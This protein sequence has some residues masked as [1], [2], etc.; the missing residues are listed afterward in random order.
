M[1]SFKKMLFNWKHISGFRNR[2]ITYNAKKFVMTEY[3]VNAPNKLKN[4]SIVFFSDTHFRKSQF[5]YAEL[6]EYIN[7][8]K[9]DWIVFGGDLIN[10]MSY[11]TSA[12]EFLSQL[13][14]KKAKLAVLGNWEMRR[15]KWATHE[16]WDTFFKKSG[17][18]LLAD[19]IYNSSP[20]HFIGINPF[21]E[22]AI[23]PPVPSGY[24]SC[25]ISHYP[26][27]VIDIFNAEDFKKID[28]IL[29]GHTH[30][31]Q[32]RLP[33]L[34]ALKTSNNYWK[35]LEY[36]HYQ[37]KNTQSNM[38]ISNGIGYSGPKYRFLCKP[39]IV[40]INFVK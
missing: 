23:L 38:I 30:G 25:L 39:E 19:S 5:P 28:L 9:T 1:Q 29:C 31:G 20:L 10:D 6:T 17:F 40:R 21:T 12:I 34:G 7:A 16:F 2:N 26:D 14:A 15:I 32:I 27:T 13:K 11:C 24:C 35:L 3:E 37:N 33:Y 18:R 36:G 8:L 4:K 22:I